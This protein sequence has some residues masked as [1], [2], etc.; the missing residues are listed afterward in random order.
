MTGRE[1]WHKT[2]ESLR[3]EAHAPPRTRTIGVL[4][5]AASELRLLRRQCERQKNTIAK[6]EAEVAELR[7]AK[8]IRAEHIAEF[9]ARHP[10]PGRPPRPKSKF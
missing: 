1:E 3:K 4:S 7:D 8:R 10:G 6:L 9:D 5:I 2:V